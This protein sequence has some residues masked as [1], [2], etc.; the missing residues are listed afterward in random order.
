MRKQSNTSRCWRLEISGFNKYRL[1]RSVPRLK[2][3]RDREK[4]SSSKIYK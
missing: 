4:K 3:Y 2:S 1:R